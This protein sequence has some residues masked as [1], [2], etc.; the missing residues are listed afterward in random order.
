M[1]FSN[2]RNYG[3]SGSDVLIHFVWGEIPSGDVDGT[4][5]T[6]TL[7][8][9]VLGNAIDVFLNGLIQKRGEDYNLSGG[10]T[11]VFTTPPPAGSIILVDYIK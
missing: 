6:F 5:N 1:A 4:N 11:V 3:S 10:N 8:N 9:T 7:A 2:R